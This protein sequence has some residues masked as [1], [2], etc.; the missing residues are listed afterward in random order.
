MKKIYKK[1][2]KEKK[3][4]KKTENPLQQLFSKKPNTVLKRVIVCMR[5]HLSGQQVV[6]VVVV[7]GVRFVLFCSLG[8]F[9]F[10]D[11]VPPPPR[12]ICRIPRR[13]T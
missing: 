8:F 10:L 2:E 6:V 4:K 12:S 7:V 1:M 13:R 11:H 9:P 3:N 5:V